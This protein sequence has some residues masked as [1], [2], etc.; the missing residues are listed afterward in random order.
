MANTNRM[1]EYHLI[2]ELIMKNKYGDNSN[3]SYNSIIE[4]DSQMNDK[5]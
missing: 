5:I 1:I 2:L 3:E 4:L